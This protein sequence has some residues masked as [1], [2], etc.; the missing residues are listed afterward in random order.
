ML[1][2]VVIPCDALTWTSVNINVGSAIIEI[3]PA[4][5]GPDSEFV[6]LLGQPRRIFV[7]ILRHTRHGGWWKVVLVIQAPVGSKANTRKSALK[8]NK[9]LNN[10]VFFLS[11]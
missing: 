8:F 7:Q 6:A 2:T 10:G 4:I 3:H 5:A 1:Q 9:L 11:V